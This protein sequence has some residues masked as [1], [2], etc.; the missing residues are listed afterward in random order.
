[1]IFVETNKSHPFGAASIRNTS[2]VLSLDPV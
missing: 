1:M 2:C